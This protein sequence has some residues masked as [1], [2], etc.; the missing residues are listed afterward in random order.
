ME[1]S[2][3]RRCRRREVVDTLHRFRAGSADTLEGVVDGEPQHRQIEGITRLE[4]CREARDFA[5]KQLIKRMALV[6]MDVS[7]VVNWQCRQQFI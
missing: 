6:M 2:G 3:E 7:I 5:Q 1:I 4:A